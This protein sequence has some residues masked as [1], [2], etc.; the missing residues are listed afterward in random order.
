M[1]NRSGFEASGPD[2]RT[3][4]GISAHC[5]G[6]SLLHRYSHT[7]AAVR[8]ALRRVEEDILQEHVS[9]C[10]ERAMLTGEES[11]KLEKLEELKQVLNRTMR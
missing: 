7:P 11:E 5:R 6:R 2:R 1:M 3:D 10:L 4:P 9:T 8:A